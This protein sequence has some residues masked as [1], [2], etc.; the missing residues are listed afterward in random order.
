MPKQRLFQDAVAHSRRRQ[1]AGVV[2]DVVSAAPKYS[3][4]LDNHNKCTADQVY[5]AHGV[6][7]KVRVKNYLTGLD[8]C[9][10]SVIIGLFSPADSSTL[11]NY[12]AGVVRELYNT[13]MS[14]RLTRIHSVSL[15]VRCLLY[16]Q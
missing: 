14:L 11:C 6:K 15:G 3:L 13:D 9:F 12:E 2:G 1:E 7:N 8:I 4:I 5:V 16:L 10:Q